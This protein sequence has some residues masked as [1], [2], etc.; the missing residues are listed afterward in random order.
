MSHDRT[1]D[2]IVY[3]AT[4]FTGGLVAHYL[5]EHG[6]R[7]LRWALAGRSRT[8]LEALRSDLARTSSALAS[9]PIVEASADDPASLAR[10][11]AQTRVVLTTVGPYALYGEP[12][13][14][15]CV[16]AATDYVDITGEPAFVDRVLA[17]YDARAREKGIRIVHCCGFDSI[18][19][20]L[21]AYFT[22]RELPAT[23]PMTVRGFVRT[24]GT[25]SGGT[26]HSA[27]NAMADIGALARGKPRKGEPSGAKAKTPSA[28]EDK[29]V[30][31][32][33]P[34]AIYRERALSAWAVPLPTIDPAIVLRS[35][36]A[37]EAYGPLF[38]YGHY[39]AVKRLPTVIAGVLGV[40]A[41]VAL[42]QNK[43][44]RAMLLDFRKP[45]EGP[46]EAER[47]K[48]WFEVTFLGES[49]AGARV[50]TKVSGGEPGYAETSKMI[51]ESALCLALDR[52]R[53]P[54][55]HGVVTTATAM[56]DRLIERLVAAGMRFEVLSRDGAPA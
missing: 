46:T 2:V 32:G 51:A 28:S 25:F 9:L 31:E 49:G 29:R 1:F 34:M 47:K 48:G 4:G 20:D 41:L 12:V 33:L 30:V 13:V 54:Q 56:G 38:R 50:V 14:A 53:L 24:R 40:G 22:A 37:L 23:A 15:A 8:K 44:T 27:L 35:A 36:R 7:D 16:D 3:G 18:P 10:M 17:T 11:A 21:G 55:R 52:E 19:H 45:G 5:A 39:A 26:W 6:P 42:A 43:R